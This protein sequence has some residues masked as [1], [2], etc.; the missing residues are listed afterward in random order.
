MVCPLTA[1]R[2]DDTIV[3]LQT[4]VILR[5]IDINI[6]YNVIGLLMVAIV[7]GKK[8]FIAIENE[9]M[10]NFTCNKSVR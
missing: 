2:I 4:N 7:A 5:R 10:K 6:P 9:C 1:M 3:I 8:S